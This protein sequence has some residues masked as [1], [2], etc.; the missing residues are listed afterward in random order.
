M[1][2]VEFKSKDDHS[3]FVFKDEHNTI[4]NAIRRVI[5][6]D[7]PTMA[8]EEV[9]VV[10]NESPLYSE[11]IA[12]RLGLI[13]LSTDYKTYSY[14]D[15]GK[16]NDVGVALSEVKMSLSADK[17]GYVYSGDI[18]SD[19]PK[20]A[21]V[22]KEIPISKIV[23]KDKK[24]EVNMSAYLGTGRDHA[25]WSP[26]HSYLKE[27]GKNIELYVEPF[28]QLDSK[29]IYNTAIDILKDK[30]EELEEKL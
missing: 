5:I 21:P 24:L 4:V 7:V 15:V 16:Q 11:T 17:E 28:G 10:Q 23:G 19:D 22:D 12:H 6:D 20:V 13:P 30:I 26:A 9:E 29:E 2:S 1:A 27:E 8:I 3:V 14:K 18:K 25:K